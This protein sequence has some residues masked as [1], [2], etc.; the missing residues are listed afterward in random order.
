MTPSTQPPERAFPVGMPITVLFVLLYALSD[1]WALDD[2]LP[3]VRGI[4]LLWLPVGMFLFATLR[5]ECSD[6]IETLTFSAVGS[7]ALSTALSFLTDACAV[8][9]PLA[10]SAVWVIRALLLV[11]ACII[12]ARQMR[13][14]PGIWKERFRARPDWTL[15]ALLVGSLC[16]TA[17]YQRPFEAA[18]QPRQ[19]YVLDGD[20][21]Y[22][23]ALAYELQR[24]SPPQDCP[25]RAGVPERAYHQLPHLTLALL[26]EAAGQS[27]L[28]RL[29]LTVFYSVLV[30]TLAAVI[31]CAGCALGGSRAAGLAAVWLLFIGAIPTPPLLPHPF[32]LFYF[33]VLPQCSSSVEP[34]LLTSPQ[35][36]CG[37]TVG[38]GALLGL[39]RVQH[40]VLEGKSCRRLSVLTALLAA[41]TLRFRVQCFI[42]LA[43]LVCLTFL[44]LAVRHRRWS[45]CAAGAVLALVTGAELAEMRLPSYLPNTDQVVFGY[46]PL[47]TAWPYFKD[48]PGSD[49]VQQYLS[50]LS[51]DPHGW[52]W[53]VANL[54]MFCL[55]NMLG[56]PLLAMLL[57]FVCGA[58]R[59]ARG[60]ADLWILAALCIL[61]ECAAMLVSSRYD[62][63]S[64]GGQVPLHIGW[65]LLPFGAVGLWRVMQGLMRLASCP[66]GVASCFFWALT[67]VVVSWQM[68][69]GPAFPQRVVRSRGFEFTTDLAAVWDY[70]RVKLPS[71]AVVMCAWLPPNTAT[72][73]GIG[74]RRAYLDYVPVSVLLDSLLPPQDSARNRETLIRQVYLSDK[75][76]DVARLLRS[77]PVTHL[78]ELGRFSL[79]THPAD[80]LRLAWESPHGEAK[81]WEIVRE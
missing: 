4:L 38:W 52:L 44:L 80:L 36:F 76:A 59:T 45:L 62:T 11:G 19:R 72:W 21:T 75:P 14:L 60:R 81:I 34:T 66:R 51:G 42:V 27:D 61:I 67:V 48:W 53:Q 37:L 40:S 12:L 6:M 32:H 17:R 10:K 47:A 30:V 74:G 35:M 28:L 26:G 58:W 13:S 79:R 33:T 29:H 16:A 50:S 3:A 1:V 78:I 46:N 73:S 55:L 5:G 8:W 64:V 65:Y 49:A 56:I 70:C 2:V 77:T 43:P 63:Y 23:T 22:F 9:W 31:F 57:V 15:V 68:I 69:R 18:G 24:G 25:I 7:L 20:Q 39:L 54:S 41:L 71:S